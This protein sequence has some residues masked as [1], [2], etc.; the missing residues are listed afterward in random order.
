MV[1]LIKNSVGVDGVA[2][3]GAEG[4]AEG[5]ADGGGRRS[6]WLESAASA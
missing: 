6:L 5:G 4:G 3:G 2:D 1:Q